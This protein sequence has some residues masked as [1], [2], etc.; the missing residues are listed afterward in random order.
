MPGTILIW[1]PQHIID[2]LWP[3]H[4]WYPNG[5]IGKKGYFLLVTDR[6]GTGGEGFAL[7]LKSGGQST[8]CPPPTFWWPRSEDFIFL[9]PRMWRN[10]YKLQMKC[11]CSACLHFHYKLYP[12]PFLHCQKL[13]RTTGAPTPLG[14]APQTPAA[15]CSFR[16]LRSGLASP[17]VGDNQITDDRPNKSWFR[18]PTGRVF[19]GLL[20]KF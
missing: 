16:S 5:L 4:S 11:H 20:A 3:V 9:S 13:A 6:D 14:A 17:S 2:A 8:L 1:K 12:D 15:A 18:L 19:K 7:T 10:I